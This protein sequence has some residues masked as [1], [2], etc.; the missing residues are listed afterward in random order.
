MNLYYTV[1]FRK[2]CQVTQVPRLSKNRRLGGS[3]HSDRNS[4]WK[5]SKTR[6][7]HFSSQKRVLI[8]VRVEMSPKGSA[9]GT[10]GESCSKFFFFFPILILFKWMAHLILAQERAKACREVSVE[11]LWPH[12]FSISVADINQFIGPRPFL[13]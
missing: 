10:T 12:R 4:T 13:N 6:R 9:W 8:P 1:Q 3:H 7:L 2:S 11:S 5:S